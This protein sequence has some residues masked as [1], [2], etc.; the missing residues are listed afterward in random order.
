MTTHDRVPAP[1]ISGGSPGDGLDG[2]IVVD[3]PAAWTSHDVVNK[4]RRLAHT[5]KVGHL[6]TLDPDATGVLP[7]VIGRATRLAQFFSNHEK[8]YEGVIRFGFSTDTYDAAGEP[9]S[10]ETNVT[11]SWGAVER[12][13]SAFRGEILQTPPAVSAKKLHGTPAYKLA[14]KK[15][16]VVLEPVSVKIHS[17]ELLSVEGDDAAI[18]LRCSAGTYVRSIAHDVGAAMGCGAH[19]KTLRRV[20][21][22]PFHLAQTHTLEQIADLSE[23]DLLS[24]LLIPLVELLPE[25]PCESVDEIIAQQIRHGRAFHATSP[26]VSS[27]ARY[28]KAISEGQLIAIGEHR[29]AHTYHPVVVL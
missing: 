26:N 10:P 13:L 20:A 3:K 25:F 23:R 29:E 1:S 28:I 21:S 18:R 14:K 22:G 19:L 5:R 9:T 11:I 27:D 6:G 8:Q 2:V 4:M 12:A 24:Q 16:A 17:L 7:L 15:L